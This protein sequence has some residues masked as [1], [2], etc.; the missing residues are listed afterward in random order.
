MHPPHLYER[1]V[2]NSLSSQPE[3]D[4]PEAMVSS[5]DIDQL[6]DP[7]AAQDA[8]RRLLDKGQV[9]VHDGHWRLAPGLQA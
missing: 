6:D 3:H 2:I 4:T 8:L 7:A 9:E 1:L 5:G